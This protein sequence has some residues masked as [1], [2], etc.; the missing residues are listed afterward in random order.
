[1][2]AIKQILKWALI[3][4]IAFCT[5]NLFI[6]PEYEFER[7]IEIDVP[8]YVVSD[9]VSDLKSW[10]HWAVW[11]KQDTGM[12]TTYS[13]AEKGVGARMD[14]VGSDGKL[15]GLEIVEANLDSMRTR[16]DFGNMFPTGIW[17]FEIIE[18]NSTKVSWGMKGKM[19]FFMRF[20]TL[21]F[22]KMGAPDFENG[23]IGL[24]AYCE[25][26]PSRSSEAEVVDWPNQNYILL[27]VECELT[28]IGGAI[29]EG[30][31]TIFAHVGEN[32][33]QPTSAPFAMWGEME[34]TFTADGLVQFEVGVMV[35]EAVGNDQIKVGKTTSKRALQAIHYGA[36]QMSGTTYKVLE[37]Y[38]KEN[39]LTVTM[40][41]S[42]EFYTNDP[43]LVAPED[44]ETLVVFEIEE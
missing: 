26:I 35:Q 13:G 36:Y 32:N 11:W 6:S 15:G 42:Y 19:P 27:H 43:T 31:G 23:L 2:N 16:L 20:M 24:K 12:T 21:F 39:E 7:S 30:L 1:M 28:N 5:F 18:D 38:A 17:K 44:V 33:L 40:S 10:Q 37:K 14:W 4:F 22:E 34:N 25:K 29:G 3:C 9:Q 41:K 8:Q